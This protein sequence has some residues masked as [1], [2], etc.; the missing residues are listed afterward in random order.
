MKQPLLT[1]RNFLETATTALTG[2][3]LLPQSVFSAP[4]I[5]KNLG[6][7]N[8]KFNGVQIGVITYSFRSL[9]SNAEQIL[10]YCI[11]CNISAIE[12][13]GNVAE[14]FAGA[15]HASTEPMQ[16]FRGTPGQRPELTPEQ[17]AEQAAKAKD[18]ADWRAKVAM[19]KF[20]QLR[21]LYKAAGV[22]IYAY[23]PN[24]FGVNNTDSEIDYGLRAAKALGATHV[25]LE[26]PTDSAQT[27]RLANIAAK[28][29]VLVAYHGHLQQT[30]TLWDVALGQSKYNALNCDLGHY[31]AAG[32]NALELL[33]AKHDRIASAHLK[34]RQNPAHGKENLPWGTGDTPLKDILQLMRKNKYTFPGTVELEYQIPE[35][36][37]A[38]KEVAKCVE[39]CRQALEKN[40]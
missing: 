22:S 37:T 12:L 20:E 11:E 25:T 13:M 1:R 17:K 27:Q 3:V 8:S 39:Y 10:Q 30:P 5:L 4:A 32:H 34:D 31:T 26:M 6:K 24:A 29:K 7:P 33:E 21:S 36:S 18:I 19:D 40:G 28:H 35:G 9:P 16:P 38:V 14:A 2:A 15:P 23:K